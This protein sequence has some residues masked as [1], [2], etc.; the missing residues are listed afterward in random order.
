MAETGGRRGGRRGG[1]AHVQPTEG[2][3]QVVVVLRQR[4]RTLF[5]MGARTK[6]SKLSGVFLL[7]LVLLASSYCLLRATAAGSK[8]YYELLGVPR[9]A[10]DNVIKKQFRKLAL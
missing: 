3:A 4:S 2:D 6:L 7:L 10:P 5:G 8:D 1:A 9:D